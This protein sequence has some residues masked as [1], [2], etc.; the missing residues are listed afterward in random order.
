[1]PSSERVATARRHEAAIHEVP[2]Y[3]KSQMGTARGEAWALVNV[4]L[5][6]EGDGLG[7]EA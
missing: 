3:I 7:V 1:M 5:L 4:P 6:V 2:G